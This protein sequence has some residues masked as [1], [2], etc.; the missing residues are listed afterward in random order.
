M[1]PRHTPAVVCLVGDL[2]LVQEYAGACEH[3]GFTLQQLLLHDPLR[4]RAGRFRLPRGVRLVARPSRG[5]RTAVELTNLSADTKRKN[6]HLLDSSLP[7]RVPI[8]T[9]SVTVTLR[10]Q[11]GWVRHPERL[12]GIGAFPTLLTGS[13]LELVS[14][15]GTAPSA[16]TAAK[17]F[18]RALGKDPSSVQDSPGMVMPRILACLIN[19]AFFALGE[20][21]A[22]PEDLDRAMK[23][24]TRYP[25]GPLEW[26]SAIGLKH[27]LAVMEALHR[28]FGEDRYR[29]APRL[30]ADAGDSLEKRQK[31]AIF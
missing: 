9:S 7:A 3:A 2:P 16:L 30:R 24:G 17:D 26:G 15:P 11:A 31:S 28:F 29:P 1:T 19:E 12:V 8:L 22:R 6:L 20:E 14:R 21:V 27:V 4:A 13:V 25:A 10:D 18:A 5:V 23:L